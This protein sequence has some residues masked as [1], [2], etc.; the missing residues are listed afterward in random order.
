MDPGFLRKEAHPS[1]KG[2]TKLFSAICVEKISWNWA[3][4]K[5]IT[6]LPTLTQLIFQLNFIKLHPVEDRHNHRQKDDKDVSMNSHYNKI[7]MK[8]F[9][10]RF[11]RSKVKDKWFLWETL[12]TAAYVFVKSHGTCGRFE[13]FTNCQKFLIC[14]LCVS[15]LEILH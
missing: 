1:T 9:N 12:E 5:Q 11:Q 14:H 3:M 10:K 8:T 15:I 6:Q 2:Y 7:L 13:F 4:N